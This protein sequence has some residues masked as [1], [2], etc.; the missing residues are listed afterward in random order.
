MVRVML[1][2]TPLLA[3][4][5]AAAVI[6]TTLPSY[7]LGLPART[8][9]E[10]KLVQGHALETYTTTGDVLDPEHEDSRLIYRR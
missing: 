6:G 7:S 1:N 5:I 4:V 3:A 10:E 8:Q 9:D 2:S